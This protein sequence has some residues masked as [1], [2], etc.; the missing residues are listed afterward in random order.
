MNNKHMNADDV[1]DLLKDDKDFI[2][3][4]KNNDVELMRKLLNKN[5]LNSNYSHGL[6]MVDYV[7]NRFYDSK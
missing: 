1:Y 6:Q 3:S 2:A 5:K 7:D 4:V